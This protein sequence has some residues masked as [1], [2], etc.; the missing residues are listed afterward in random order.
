[1]IERISL[2]F[3][4]APILRGF[5]AMMLCGSVFP[6]CGV[7]VLRLNLVPMRYMLMHGVILGGAVSLAMNLPLVPVSVVVNL[8]LIFGMLI[9]TKDYNFG[10][11]AGSGAA[12]VISMALASII[13]HVADV[14]AKDTLSL[15]WG[16]PFALSKFDLLILG[17][18]SVVL[19]L[20]VIL[21]FK[22]ILALFFNREIALSLGIKVQLHYGL[23]VSVVAVVV[24]VA[25]KLLGA[26][27]IDSLLILPV[28]SAA[29]CE[30]KK[31]GG[32]KQIFILSSVYGFC[33]SVFGYILAVMINWP[34]ASTVSVVAGTTFLVTSIVNKVRKK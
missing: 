30:G 19:I 1:M 11:G 26:F 20:Y 13:M 25:M 23:M 9:F 33:F 8:L 14:P 31:S 27:L 17:V 4:L 22:N 2:L 21:N 28:L 18:I 3:L 6:V 15:M 5:L 7:M 12:M 29:S 10:F 24:A 32:I 16:S 34:P